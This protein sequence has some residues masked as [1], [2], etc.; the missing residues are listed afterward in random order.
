MAKTLLTDFKIGGDIIDR[1]SEPVTLNLTQEGLLVAVADWYTKALDSHDL[2]RGNLEKAGLLDWQVVTRLGIGFSEGSLSGVLSTEQRKELKKLGVL[3][4]SGEEVLTGCLVIPLRDETSAITGFWG[5]DW[6]TKTLVVGQGFVNRAALAVWR[7]EI[8]FT[9]DPREGLALLIIGVENLLITPQGLGAKSLEALKTERVR[10]VILLEDSTGDRDQLVNAGFQA[11]VLSSPAQGSW[12]KALK[13][14]VKKDEV[15]K[16]ISS[17]QLTG[18]PK[19]QG[20][21]WIRDPA[22][23]RWKLETGTLSY[24]VTGMKEKLGSSLRI[25]VKMEK[26]DKKF[27]D[28]VDLYSSRSRVAFRSEACAQLEVETA[29]IEQDLL[30]LLDLLEAEEERKL[31][32]QEHKPRELTPAERELGMSLLL[33]PTLLDDLVSDMEVLGHEGEQTNKKLVYLAASSRKLSDPVSV[34]IVSQ[35]AAGKSYLIDTVRKLMPEEDVVN[36][37][38][39]SDQALNYMGESD[40]MHKLLILGEAIHNEVVEHQIREMLSAK[41]LS[42]MVVTKHERTGKMGSRMVKKQAVV[43][44]MM[45]STK[46][47]LNPENASR[48]FLLHADE[49]EEQT[50]RIHQRQNL[51]YS[52]EEMEKYNHQTPQVIAK[53]KAAQ[54]LLKPVMIVNPWAHGREFPS[55]LMRS[56]RDNKQLGELTAAVCFLRQYQKEIKTTLAGQDVVQYIECDESDMETAWGLFKDGV[57]MSTYLEL[58]VSLVRLYEEIRVLCGEIAVKENLGITQVS[59]DQGVL[60]KRVKWL[61]SESVKK[62]LR[63]L[64]S[65]EYLQMK[66]SYGRGQRVRYSLMEDLSPQELEGFEE[67]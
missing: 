5:W 13:T 44:L 6:N 3:D 54:R 35:S 38:S 51:K 37:T 11:G 39:V 52:L 17:C 48:M 32:A 23:G 29:A 67:K 63:K 55:T 47:D 12:L 41:E 59:F 4:S 56:R 49:S 22:S 19:D 18:G 53:H 46:A 2:S 42:R 28:S 30:K 1:V 66:S 7:E 34:V 8:L 24:L 61:G 26:G 62:Y 33:S 16:L 27:R 15:R 50:R 40:L 21:Q 43:S 65:L 25:N 64:V 60:R 31:S 9:R 36:L 20:S 14:G 58:P 10:K 57:M 45:S